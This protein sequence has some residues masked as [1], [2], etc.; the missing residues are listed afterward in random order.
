MSITGPD[1]L[2]P[3]PFSRAASLPHRSQ[4]PGRAPAGVIEPKPAAVRPVSR[5]VGAVVSGRVD[6]SGADGPRPGAPLSMY[7]R[8]ADKNAAATGVSAGRF[9]DAEA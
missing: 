2:G 1:P 7:T 3:I 9:L 5:L 6:F 4:A 8:P